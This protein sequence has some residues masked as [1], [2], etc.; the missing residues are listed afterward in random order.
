[1]H[2]SLVPPGTQHPGAPNTS[3]GMRLNPFEQLK[4]LLSHKS[5]RAASTAAMPT[6]MPPAPALCQG[7]LA[8]SQRPPGRG[9]EGP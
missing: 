1:M 9:T 3:M 4:Q 8:G 5:P 6:V 2:P 7:P